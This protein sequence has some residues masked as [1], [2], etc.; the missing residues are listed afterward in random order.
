RE[1]GMREIIFDTETTG[2]DPRSGDRI[3]EF[4]AIELVDRFATGRSFHVYI[5][6]E[7]DMPAAAEKVH[8]LSAAF[9][10]D[11]PVF[12]DIVDDMMRFIGDAVLVAHNASFDLGFLNAE[13]HACKRGNIP[14]DRVIDTL[15]IA[16]RK[17][18][19]VSNTLDA[20]C[21]RYGI[22]RSARA[23]AHGALLD[24]QLLA[25]VY[26]DLIDARQ[27]S[28]LGGAPQGARNGMG[29]SGQGQPAAPAPAETPARTRPTPLRARVTPEHRAAHAAFIETLGPDAIWHRYAKPED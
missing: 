8:G 19:Q 24:S 22:D 18:G 1:F 20:L 3:V 2:L 4:G 7:R 23:D 16:R 26:I 14:A 17:H 10:A 28:L 5:N 27:T 11:K 6:P 13:L 21:D 29:R 9:L 25:E 15:L 12:K